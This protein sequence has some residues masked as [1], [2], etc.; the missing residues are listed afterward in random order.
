VWQP[1]RRAFLGK[2]ARAS[3]LCAIG[4]GLWSYLLEQQARASPFALRPP[5][6][7]PEPRFNALCIKCGQ[8]IAACPY[9]TLQLAALGAPV[10][11]GTPHFVPRDVP[12]YMCPDIPC[13]RAC[14]TGALDHGLGEIERARMGLAVID[15]ENCLSWQGLRCEICHRACPLIDRAI[16]V[17]HHPRQISKH[18]MFV[19]VVHSEHCTGC[20]QCEKACPLEKAAIRVLPP[21]LVQGKIG[22][23]YRLGWTSQSPITQH[24]VP[25]APAPARPPPETPGLDYL[26]EGGP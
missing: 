20:G 25:Q 7:V 9:Q 24:F 26:N 21:S 11:I 6:A 19:P 14:P 18:A 17:Q 8:C 15:I 3:A 23:H 1:S 4:G 2:L 10:P 22:E 5:G 12:C 13:E 16:S